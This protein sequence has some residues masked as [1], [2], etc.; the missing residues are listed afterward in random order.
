MRSLEGRLQLGLAL[1]LILLMGLVW[2]VGNQAIRAM[3]ESF[4]A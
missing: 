1:S 4:V 2:L 3:T